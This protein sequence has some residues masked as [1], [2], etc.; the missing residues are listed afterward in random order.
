MPTSWLG[1]ALFTC[2]HISPIQDCIGAL[3]QFWQRASLARVH[4]MMAVSSEYL[5]PLMLFVR[6]MMYEMCCLYSDWTAEE[7]KKSWCLLAP[8]IL[9]NESMS[10]VGYQLRRVASGG[11]PRYATRVQQYG[12]RTCLRAPK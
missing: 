6:P 11:R 8:P 7:V 5:R 4:A 3:P 9:T 12:G 1:A 10:P 2:A